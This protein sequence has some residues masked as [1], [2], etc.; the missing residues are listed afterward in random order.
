M[1]RREHLLTFG[2]LA[3]LGCADA[4]GREDEVA[5]NSA[6]GAALG[7]PLEAAGPQWTRA[8]PRLLRAP[9][10]AA[11]ENPALRRAYGIGDMM[12]GTCAKRADSTIVGAKCGNGYVVFGPY[13]EVPAN[14]EVR[15][16]FELHALGKLEFSSD[17]VSN[18]RQI[19]GVLEA[20]SLAAGE[21]RKLGYRIHLSEA[22]K[23]LEARVWVSSEKP[24]DFEIKN[25]A[26]TVQ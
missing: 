15:V 21:S 19:L 2:L 5:P 11:S 13:V 7:P 20:Q 18:V 9:E 8:A 24:V 1:F 16:T 6:K 3:M 26:L 22:A 23:A 4:K 10:A 17:I 14:S 25:L 12:L